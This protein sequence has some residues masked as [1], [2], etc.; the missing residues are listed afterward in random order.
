[1]SKPSSLHPGLMN[2]QTT[3][4]KGEA[5]ATVPVE[6][7][8][9]IGSPE[10]SSL[11]KAEAASYIE[12]AVVERNLPTKSMTVKIDEVSYKKLKT[13][14]L[15]IGKTSQDIFVAALALYFKVNKL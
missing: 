14:G 4:A 2:V 3:A 9:P 7:K 15:H 8:A 1:M 11:P 12:P 10:S 13:H 5:R 6:P